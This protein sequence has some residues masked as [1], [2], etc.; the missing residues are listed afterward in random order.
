MNFYETEIGRTFFEHQLPQLIQA[1]QNISESLTRTAPTL[2]LPVAADPDFLSELYLGNYEAAVFQQT[3]ATASLN[4]TV[5]EKLDLLLSDLPAN[6]QQRFLEY[7]EA[8]TE[9]NSAV[10]ELAYKSG[11]SAAVQMILAGLSAP[12]KE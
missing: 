1:L 12:G 11:F 3:D 2:E 4:H 9:L 8:A 5:V 6:T 10:T 7:K